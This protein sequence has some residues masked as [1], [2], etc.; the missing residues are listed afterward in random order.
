MRGAS[1]FKNLFD[2][3]EPLP[4]CI[5]SKGRN[6]DHDARRN[7]ALIARYYY[8]GRYTGNRYSIIM[9][10]LSDEFYLSERR[11]QDIMQQQSEILHKLRQEQPAPAWFNHQFPHLVWPAP[12][13]LNRRVA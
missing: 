1:L 13:K 8:L 12:A 5:R 4:E 7:E 6:A 11:I 2:D 3:L 9:R 10:Q